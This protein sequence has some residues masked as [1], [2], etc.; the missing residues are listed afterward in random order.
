MNNLINFDA[1]GNCSVTVTD[2]RKDISFLMNPFFN[3][4]KEN[5][6][7][8]IDECADIAAR[9]KLLVFLDNYD[10][11][12]DGET[13]KDISATHDSVVVETLPSENGSWDVKIHNVTAPH[14][15]FWYAI[16]DIEGE[17]DSIGQLTHNL[18]G[19]KTA[20]KNI[21]ALIAKI[22]A[23]RNTDE[24]IDYLITLGLDRPQ[25]KYILD[26]PIN[27]LMEWSEPCISDSISRCNTMIQFLTQIKS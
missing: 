14:S 8:D 10:S 12:F 7:R 22:K 3:N 25:A 6:L 11:L 5:L 15:G 2:W 20:T 9:E 26:Y 21:D 24:A 16:Q 19:L 1:H 18:E 13:S 17:R 4:S 23:A 27:Q